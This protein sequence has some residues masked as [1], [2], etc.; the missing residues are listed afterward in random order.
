[1]KPSLGFPPVARRDAQILILGSL[2]GDASI[3]KLQY[4][5]HPQNAFWRLMEHIY[6]IPCDAPY[7]A[8]LNGLIGNKVAL[9]DVCHSAHRK[10]SLDLAIRAAVPNDL[11]SFLRE[12]HQIE[13]ILFNG[14]FAARL[15]T[16]H[17][18]DEIMITHCLPS[19]S[20]AHAGMSFDHKCQKWKQALG[21]A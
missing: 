11:P 7:Q 12:H 6:G 17:F 21:K 19:T 2:P 1:M 3:R 8:R 18:P 5:G 20:P 13:N 16:K 10:G 9:W 14:Q 4:Y 15:Y